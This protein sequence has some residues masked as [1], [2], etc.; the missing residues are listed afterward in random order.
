MHCYHQAHMIIQE[1]LK[2]DNPGATIVP[3]IISTNKTLLTLFYNKNT[4]PIYLTIGNIP[5]EI[6]CKPTC[7][8][9]VL[10]GYLPT[11]HLECE[12]NKASHQH[13]PTNLHHTCM[14]KIL[15]PLK[16]TGES[17][18]FMTMGD[19]IT[20]QNHPLLACFTGIIQNRS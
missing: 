20:H 3:I 11:I 6:H 7:H 18:I 2:Q 1:A 10:L 13:Q 14:S 8:A 12:A 5:K 4:Y 19:G 16:R 17:G 9:Y 15:H